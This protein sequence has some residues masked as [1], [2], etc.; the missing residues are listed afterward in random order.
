MK[1]KTKTTMLTATW[2]DVELAS[3]QSTITSVTMPQGKSRLFGSN[4]TA[5][6]RDQYTI[7][8]SWFALFSAAVMLGV[9]FV[10]Y[11]TAKAEYDRSEY[12]E[13]L[14]PSEMAGCSEGEHKKRYSI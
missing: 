5:R 2:R 8:M 13:S 7:L 6:S 1:F 11:S 12:K 4:I 10:N 9:S 14:V 3:T